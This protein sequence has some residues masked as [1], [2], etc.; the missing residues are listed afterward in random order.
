MMKMMNLP[1]WFHLERLPATNLVVCLDAGG[2]SSCFS[3]Y[4]HF[5][6]IRCLEHLP[7]N[8]LTSP[9]L[10][11]LNVAIAGSVR[12]WFT[13]AHFSNGHDVQ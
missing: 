10:L 13:A 11:C 2:Y 1:F 6:Y 4:G 9:N 5:F 3:G 8:A 7:S 12:K